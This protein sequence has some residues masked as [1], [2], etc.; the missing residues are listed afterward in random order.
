[1]LVEDTPAQRASGELLE[2][3]IDI[4]KLPLQT[5][6]EID[7]NTGSL[8]PVITEAVKD[9]LLAPPSPS[10]MTEST[11]DLRGLNLGS[12]RS[13]TD[14]GQHSPNRRPS[15]NN[16][17]DEDICSSSRS[18][19]RHSLSLLR[20]R[21][22]SRSRS[23]PTSPRPENVE[24]WSQS[25]R[26]SSIT[27]SSD[28]FRSDEDDEDVSASKLLS[29]SDIFQSPTLQGFPL[30]QEDRGRR[31]SIGRKSNQSSTTPSVAPTIT[32]TLPKEHVT[33]AIEIPS[34]K[35]NQEASSER[36]GS[37][38]QDIV[39]VG[40][41]PLKQAV[42]LAGWMKRRSQRVSEIVS[43]ESLGY[44]EKV[45]DM[46][47]G[48]KHH[49][50]EHGERIVHDVAAPEADADVEEDEEEGR[51]PN[52]AERF[53]QR[54]ALSKHEKLLA[55]YFGYLY[56][57]LPVYGKIYLGSEHLCFRPIMPGAKIRVRLIFP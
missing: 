49:Y 51:S 13:S 22:M 27:A 42:G 53:R 54:F 20:D 17:R 8:T 52:P 3:G 18:A 38:L 35:T 46:W 47:T 11:P 33:N 48:G 19:A 21:D 28:A 2:K 37:S 39:K 29:G 12:R 41:Y 31:P 7:A 6:V 44:M 56:K 32:K 25:V 15:L 5:K 43:S 40:S 24:S 26:G 34:T 50:D 23:R 30:S 10:F 16:S 36:K 45:S 55:A 1:L 9:T 57:G 4:T 14:T